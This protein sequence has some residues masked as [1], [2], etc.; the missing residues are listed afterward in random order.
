M[1]TMTHFSLV[2]LLYEHPQAL[3]SYES[4]PSFHPHALCGIQFASV[5][6]GIFFKGP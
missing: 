2:W 5:L 3:L 4:R 1:G 6:P